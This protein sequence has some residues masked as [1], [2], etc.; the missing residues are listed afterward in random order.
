MSNCVELQNLDVQIFNLP[1]EIFR[2][3][4]SYLDAD[5]L[6]LNLKNTCHQMR[7]FVTNYVEWEQTVIMLFQG[8]Y[9]Y[10]QQG[11]PMEAVHMI[12]LGGRK[13]HIYKRAA[14]PDFPSQPVL[15]E[16]LVFAATIQK[17]IVIGLHYSYG[18][19]IRS[20]EFFSLEKDKWIRI[21]RHLPEENEFANVPMCQCAN[22]VPNTS[23]SYYVSHYYEIIYSQIG[24]S[25]IILFHSKNGIDYNFIELLHFHKNEV[26]DLSNGTLTYSS[27]CLDAPKEIRSLRDFC[28]IEKTKYEFLVVG[29]W[30]YSDP[31]P[32]EKK[33]KMMKNKMKKKKKKKEEEE[34]AKK[35]TKTEKTKKKRKEEEDEY[36][37]DET[38][39]SGCLSQD[40]TQVIWKDTGHRIPVMGH[41]HPQVNK[42]FCVGQNIYLSYLNN[43]ENDC[44]LDN[45]NYERYN[46]E[47]KKYYRNVFSPSSLLN[48]YTG[49]SGNI[50][51]NKVLVVAAARI[52]HLMKRIGPHE[53][54]W[55]PVNRLYSKRQPLIFTRYE[56][57][58]YEDKYK[59][60]KFCGRRHYGEQC[61]EALFY[62]SEA[63][64]IFFLPILN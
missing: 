18:N 33:Q 30:R 10:E 4:F 6:N 49:V 37:V 15:D 36:E 40:K 48:E 20:F 46:W 45:H 42:C 28:L 56:G 51:E 52:N 44:H 34:E 2:T 1:E 3:I 24:E 50:D 61:T 58:I 64:N 63:N 55:L 54:V 7:N 13:P 47:E 11:P 62:G 57:Y 31:D 22:D 23:A 32:K 8:R 21:C 35:K 39:W 27:Y 9:T 25:S 59:N 16:H 38:V 12:K 26:T 29:G 41:F 43:L 60:C 53:S 19:H 17:R 14:F 5:D